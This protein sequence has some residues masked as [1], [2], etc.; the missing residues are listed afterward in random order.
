MELFFGKES[1]MAS[2]PSLMWV[3]LL[4]AVGVSLASGQCTLAQVED[5]AF[6]VSKV[7]AVTHNREQLTT[8]NLAR[9]GAKFGKV[10]VFLFVFAGNHKNS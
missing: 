3:L 10:K 1:R 6:A 8:V 7:P 5:A 9:F 4:A 2:L